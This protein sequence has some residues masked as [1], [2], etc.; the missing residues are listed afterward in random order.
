MR[1]LILLFGVLV[2]F[3]IFAGSFQS[4]SIGGRATG[5]AGA[6]VAIVDDPL[7]LYWNPAGLSMMKGKSLIIGNTSI[8]GI[9]RYK[10]ENGETEKNKAQWQFVPNVAFGINPGGNWS[11]GVGNFTPFGLNQ[12]WKDNAEY[13]YSSIRSE[14]WLNTIQAGVSYKVNDNLAIGGSFGE[15]FAKM[16]AKQSVMLAKLIPSPPF[17]VPVDSSAKIS[18][19]SQGM[20]GGLGFIWNPVKNISIGGRWHSQSKQYLKGKVDFSPKSGDSFQTDMRMKFTFP[21][22][23]SVG[24]A[25]KGFENWLISFQVDWTDWS[26]MGSLVEHLG[27][28]VPLITG[29]TDEVKLK[30]K[31]K[32][33]YSY[34]LGGEYIVNKRIALRLG[35]MWDPSPVP[36]ETLDPLMF[37]VSVN[38]YSV[39]LGYKADR[40]NID[41]AYMYSKGNKRKVDNSE[42]SFP[43]NGDYSGSSHV[44]D[45]SFAYVF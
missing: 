13:R 40:W 27:D 25:Y 38:R 1:Y 30:R 28:K 20:E 43:T 5:M 42:N 2:S 14:I 39:G 19:K 45:I 10:T 7:S 11:F 6:Y 21:Q 12:T 15:G 36:E 16:N 31:W 44:I 9:A 34:R 26:K 33:T 29:R 23:A 41:L 8:K 32:D 4:P 22:Y 24:L 3:S 18:A 17:V 37:D 35:Y